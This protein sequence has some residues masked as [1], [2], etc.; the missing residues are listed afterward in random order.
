MRSFPIL[1]GR[2]LDLERETKARKR[3]LIENE[4]FNGKESFEYERSET[5]A[6]CSCQPSGRGGKSPRKADDD[7]SFWIRGKIIPYVRRGSGIY[8]HCGDDSREDPPVLI[9]NT[10]VKLSYAEST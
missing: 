3:I 2:G 8:S 9:P 5:E 6:L 1:I 10:E 4:D 7:F